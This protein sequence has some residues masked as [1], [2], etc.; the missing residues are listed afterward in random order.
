MN[1][2]L[3]NRKFLPAPS[4]KK[5]TFKIAILPRV[6]IKEQVTKMVVWR[7]WLFKI[8]GGGHEKTEEQITYLS[9]L[10]T[11]VAWREKST[12]LFVKYIYFCL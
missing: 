6:Y 5:T 4:E 11:A 9:H 3:R 8:H 1:G 12:K 7:S 2:I 10:S